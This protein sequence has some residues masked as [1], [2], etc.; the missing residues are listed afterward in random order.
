MEAEFPFLLCVFGGFLGFFWCFFFF[1]QCCNVKPFL[2][3][4]WLTYLTASLVVSFL[5]CRKRRH[6]L[7]CCLWRALW[8]SVWF[9]FSWK[10]TFLPFIPHMWCKAVYRTHRLV[11]VCWEKSLVLIVPS[12]LFLLYLLGCPWKICL[13]ELVMLMREYLGLGSC[14]AASL[15]ISGISKPLLC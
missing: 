8:D 2:L 5:L 7:L 1:L 13:L 4:C 12:V 9:F 10:T 15:F 14:L 11:T 6:P 3:A